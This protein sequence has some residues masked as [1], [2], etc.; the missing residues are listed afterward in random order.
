MEVIG[1]FLFTGLIIWLCLYLLFG[2]LRV[3]SSSRKDDK[4]NK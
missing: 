2:M 4:D 1:F 3:I